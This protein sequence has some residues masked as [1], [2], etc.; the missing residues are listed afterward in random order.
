MTCTIASLAWRVAT[1]LVLASVSVGCNPRS[2]QASSGP[3]EPVNLAVSSEATDGLALIALDKGFFAQSGIAPNA[4]VTAS[5]KEALEAL[6]RGEA[7]LAF[8][9]ETPIVFDALDKPDLRI[10]AQVGRNHDEL[11]IVARRD[12]G[13]KSVADLRG[14]RVGTQEKS[15]VH[16]F[17]YLA[18][19]RH[20][21]TMADIEPVYLKADALPEALARGEIDAFAM[22][23][24]QVGRAE[25]LLG[26]KALVLSEPGLYFKLFC[27]VAKAETLKSRP[28][29]P[30]KV[31]RG[32]LMAEDFVRN[33]PLA[34]QNMIAS[35]SGIDKADLAALWPAMKLDVTLDQV[36]LVSLQ[37]EGQWP[38]DTRMT[39]R[40]GLPDYLSMIHTDALMRVKPEV[41]HVFR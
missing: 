10:V 1:I 29:L 2:Q 41:V 12:R 4:K 25:A 26:D 14:R 11:R 9:A 20:H 7:D 34:A 38:I 5:G 8:V 35:R 19:L 27:L 39:S 36:L 32:L 23:E 21:I 15:S 13:I 6:R 18:L 28:S 31:L 40:S 22:R 16:Y 37:Q 3:A 30:D 17:L 24:P 33:D